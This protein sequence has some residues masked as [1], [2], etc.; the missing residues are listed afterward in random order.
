[1]VEAIVFVPVPNYVEE[2][3]LYATREGN[4]Y[5]KRLYANGAEKFIK[6]GYM[7]SDGYLRFE[8][9]N[10]GTR[11][12]GFVHVFIAKTFIPNPD[13][14]PFVDHING[15][16]SDNRLNNLR[17]CTRQGNRRNRKK[18]EGTSSKYIGVSQR[19]NNWRSR[20]HVNN[21]EIYL[22]SFSSE[23]DAAKIYNEAARKYHGEFASLNHFSDDEDNE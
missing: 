22:G 21:I 18:I 7:H 3:Q 19:N 10:N 13:E 9:R 4:I 2:W 6:I 12:R 14:K 20:I 16:R 17:W 11:L 15:D 23:K 5:K 8:V 1:M